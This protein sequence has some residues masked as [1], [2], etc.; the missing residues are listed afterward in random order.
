MLEELLKRLKGTG[1]GLLGAVLM[2]LTLF[3]GNNTDLLNLTDLPPT[4]QLLIAGVITAVVEQITKFL[5]NKFDLEN[6]VVGGIKKLA[7][8]TEPEKT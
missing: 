7:G 3:I 1:Y 5:N 8:K 6:R 2:T 4:T